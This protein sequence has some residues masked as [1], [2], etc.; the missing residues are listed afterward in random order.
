MIGEEYIP[1]SYYIRAVLLSACMS[2]DGKSDNNFVTSYGD[3]SGSRLQQTRH[4]FRSTFSCC[5]GRLV[6]T[7]L[8]Q[9]DDVNVQLTCDL[10]ARIDDVCMCVHGWWLWWSGVMGTRGA[11]AAAVLGSLRLHSETSHAATTEN[12]ENITSVQCRHIVRP[13]ASLSNPKPKSD[14]WPFELKRCEFYRTSCTKLSHCF[15]KLFPEKKE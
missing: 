4:Y 7:D 6:Q 12:W 14:L 2:Y 3:V 15:I 5:G 1:Y 9:G 13:S 8:W 11:A 10:K